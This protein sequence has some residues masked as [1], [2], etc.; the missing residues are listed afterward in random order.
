MNRIVNTELILKK[1]N[2]TAIKSLTTEMFPVQENEILLKIEKFG[3]TANNI[4]YVALGK[5]FQYFDFFPANDSSL[6][7]VNVW[8]VGSVVESRNPKF[9]IGEKIYG[10]FPV[11]KYYCLNPTLINHTTFYVDR[12]HLPADRYVYNQYFRQLGDKEYSEKQEDHM[13]IFRPLWGTSYFLDDYLNQNQYFN[14]E[15]VIIT[16]ASSKTSYCLA[17]LLKR[18]TKKVIGLTSTGNIEF[19]KNLGLYDEVIDYKNVTSLSQVK[20]VGVDMAGNLKLNQQIS[21]HLNSNLVKFV[22]VGMSHYDANKTPALG[23]T[24]TKSLLDSKSVLFFAPEW[25]KE[26]GVN[27]KHEIVINKYLVWQEFLDFAKKNVGVD[28]KFGQAAVEETYL[29]MLSGNAKPQNGFILS[30]WDGNSKL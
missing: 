22:T 25:I 13:I 20:S 30:M 24:K 3:F 12:P 26:R 2:H 14:A 23:G 27:S 10:Y 17:L 11:A 5:S 16:S 19:C 15:N 7:K 18:R 29:T 8:G 1:S 9:K 28:V 21:D 4:T 6:A